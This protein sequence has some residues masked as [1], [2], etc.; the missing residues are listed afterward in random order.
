M[1]RDLNISPWNEIIELFAGA[2][3]M[4][5]GWHKAGFSPRA[6]V[7][8]DTAAARTHEL[9]FGSSHCLSLNRDLRTFAPADLENLLRGGSADLLAI[10]GGPPCQGWSK[11]G[12]GKL[13][14]LR[15]RAHSLLEDPR[16][17]LYRQFVRFVEHFDPPVFMMENVPGM[18]NLEG[19]N[20]ADEVVDNFDEIGFVTSYALVNARW[21][22]VP[23]DRV[24]L[25]FL[26]VRDDLD[27][28]LDAESLEEF[29]QYFRAEIANLP[30]ETNLKQALSDLPEV[31]HGI[32]E[33]PQPY[34]RG[35][36][37][38]S[39][40]AELMRAK[41]NGN[42]T[43]HICREHNEMDLEAFDLMPEGG[44]YADLPPRLQRY[45]TDIFP[46]KYRRLKWDDVSGTITAHLAKDCYQHIHP[47]QGR[48]I[49]IREAARIQ[50]FPDDFRFFG[51]MGDRYRQI[52]NAVPPLMAWG[53]AEYVR[54][55]VAGAAR[56]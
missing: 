37:R 45:R 28:S 13:R 48:T 38:I 32:R 18:L 19:R 50:S 15:G 5:W 2:G 56:E 7:D 27:F 39:K 49:S 3:G 34:R 11:A 12:R 30:G 41:S 21:F 44:I 54:E 1:Q 17:A 35:R 8:N 51:N 25:I 42:V 55:R 14:S 40:F 26:G 6:A 16:N 24:R 4:T 53:I 43:D 10:V 9:N 23:Q 46:D 36:G 29:G 20:V 52:G 33:D 47:R 31:R 22:G